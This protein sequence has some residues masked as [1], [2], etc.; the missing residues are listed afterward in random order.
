MRSFFLK[1]F[2]PL[3]KHFYP[4][5]FVAQKPVYVDRTVLPTVFRGNL[6]NQL[7]KKADPKRIDD[8]WTLS[9]VMWNRGFNEAIDKLERLWEE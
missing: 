9:A 7:R 3:V 4:E 6:I 1:L 8:T 2:L 5:L